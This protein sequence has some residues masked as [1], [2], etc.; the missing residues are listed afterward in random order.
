MES[1][2]LRNFKFKPRL[3]SEW[4]SKTEKNGFDVKQ[5]AKYASCTANK[6]K[7]GLEIFG[8][9]N[10]FQSRNMKY[11][12]TLGASIRASSSHPSLPLALLLTRNVCIYTFA[13]F[14][15]NFLEK[16]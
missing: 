8:Q 11:Y 4:S 6:K 2:F 5:L 3:N 12:V 1:I 10:S 15:L 14:L 13:I 7:N 16:E 9:F